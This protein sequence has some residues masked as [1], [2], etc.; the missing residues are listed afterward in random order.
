MLDAEDEQPLRCEKWQ[1][2]LEVLGPPSDPCTGSN[3]GRVEA[4]GVGNNEWR[5]DHMVQSV[6]ENEEISGDGKSTLDFTA[7]LD[8]K[9]TYI[10][11]YPVWTGSLKG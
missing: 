10:C 6:Q 1:T 8:V 9:Y 4:D 11:L 7:C 3:V 2:E 5:Q